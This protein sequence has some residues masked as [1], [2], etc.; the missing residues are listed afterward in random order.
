MLEQR[1]FNS[2]FKKKKIGIKKCN[3]G[4]SESFIKIGMILED[5][6]MIEHEPSCMLDLLKS[7]HTW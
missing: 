5:S 6:Q 1:A 2:W 7:C 3:V 4:E